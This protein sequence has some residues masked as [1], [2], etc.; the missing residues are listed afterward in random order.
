MNKDPEKRF[1]DY[2]EMILTLEASRRELL[3]KRSGAKSGWFG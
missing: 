2:D 3:Q 1:R